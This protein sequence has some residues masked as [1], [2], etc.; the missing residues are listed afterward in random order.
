MPSQKRRSEAV[1]AKARKSVLQIASEALPFAKTGGLADVLGALPPALARLGWDVT[2]VL[3]K[4]RGVRGASTVER[5]TVTVGGFAREVAFVEAAMDDG[6]RAMLVDCPELYDRPELYTEAGVDYADNAR[7]FAFLVRAALEFAARRGA[8]PSIVHAHDWQ[9]ALAPVYLKTLYADHPVLAGT[10]SVLTI[11]NLAFQGLFEPVWLPRLDLG[12]DQFTMDRLEYWNRISFLK[13]GINAADKITTV[14]PRY[15]EEIQ[16]PSFGFGFDGILRARAA[17][18]VGIMNGV[19]AVEWDPARDRFLPRPYSIDNLDG[20]RAAKVELLRRYR[21][22][23]DDQ[24]LA[25]PV[26]GMVSR[27][28]DQK[29]LDLIEALG[30]RLPALDASFV[31]LGTGDARY[32]DF[33]KALAAA[34][35]DR[36]G[37]RIGFDEGLAHLIEGGADLFLM[38]SRFEPSGL[39]QMYSMRYGTIPIVHAVGGLADTVTPRTGFV[40]DEYTP[41]ALLA[42]LSRALRAY[43]DEQKWRTLQRAG[44]ARDFSWDRSA[45][46]Y[47]KIYDW[48]LKRRAGTQ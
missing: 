28:V 18:L 9:G 10:P 27:M 33:W 41:D 19:D 44:M 6:A 14:S 24:T 32:Q 39:N 8:G 42:C 43:R 13:G 29:G 3:P 37:A 21:L 22:P 16:T 12:W 40:F 45:K 2:V 48:L 4:Y 23:T 31:V 34:H 1:R 20:K 15:A 47:V 26:V 17:D 25:R 7:R 11:H 36:I 30:A 38:P 35:P 5:F 46:E